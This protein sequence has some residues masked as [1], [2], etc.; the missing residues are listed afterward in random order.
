MV[1]K[2]EQDSKD[3]SNSQASVLV[4]GATG[5]VGSE[6]VKQLSEA[7]IPV[8]AAC[9]TPNKV[10]RINKYPGV[11]IITGFD[12]E[13]PETY[14]TLFVGNAML[15]S[16]FFIPPPY[17]NIVESTQMFIKKVT[18]FNREITRI[19]KLSAMGTEENASF[20]AGRLHYKT[21]KAIEDSGIKCTFLQP[22][23]F[24]QNFLHLAGDT[25]RN[26]QAFYFPAG[27]AKVSFVDV[28]DVAAIAVKI[29]T[30]DEDDFDNKYNTKQ[31]VITGPE[32]I[33]YYQAAEI[34]S[35]VT[36][37]RITY[38]DLSEEEARNEMKKSG[39]P[40]WII[41][42]LLERYEA[43]RSG[44]FSRIYPTVERMLWR[45]PIPFK[46]FVK[47]NVSAFLS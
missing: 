19:V 23:F 11:E 10:D 45:N 3:N 40:N 35:E 38:V 5:T 15:D 25:I 13:K 36:T 39:I 37:K 8:R 12:F 41:N 17:Q 32:A 46:Q 22:N 27:D 16:C 2:Q 29:L 7:R 14:D 34:L 6:I 43:S 33:S 31:F 30:E 9:H 44:H 20:T 1:S 4:T 26:K 24:M 18:R 47:D 28:R 21:E 42:L